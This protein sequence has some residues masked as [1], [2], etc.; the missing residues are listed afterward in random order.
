MK[1]ERKSE[2]SRERE[3]DREREDQS[4]W[5]QWRLNQVGLGVE[6]S[7][8]VVGAARSTSVLESLVELG[9]RSVVKIGA[10]PI[11]VDAWLAI[12]EVDLRCLWIGDEGGVG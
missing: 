10:Q 11:L 9:L 12:G 2:R 3:I 1:G 5:R 7:G 6:W 8:L 4:G